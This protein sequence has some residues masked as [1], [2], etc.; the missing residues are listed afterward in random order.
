MRIL[1]FAICEDPSSAQIEVLDG[2]SRCDA[3]KTVLQRWLDDAGRLMDL[4][5][6][7]LFESDAS[8]W[9]LLFKVYNPVNLRWWVGFTPYCGEPVE[10]IICDPLGEV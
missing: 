7:D 8:R 9:D 4:D 5:P 3:F 10:F 2:A 1:A 6:S